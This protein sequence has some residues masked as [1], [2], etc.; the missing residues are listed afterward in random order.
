LIEQAD[1]AELRRDARGSNFKASW[2]TSEGHW[3][4]RRRRE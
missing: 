1:L 2:F 3:H 4:K